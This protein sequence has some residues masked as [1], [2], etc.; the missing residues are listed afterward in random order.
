MQVLKEHNE[1]DK[2][3]I[4]GEHTDSSSLYTSSKMDVI[5]FAKTPHGTQLV[6]VVKHPRFRPVPSHRH[7][8]IE[9][10]FV[11][12]GNVVHMFEDRKV[13]LEAGD[14]LIMN[15]YTSHSVLTAGE[16]DIAVNFIIQSRF[17][18]NAY[19]LTSKHNVLSDFI[20]DLL[21]N[22]VNCNQYLH[23]KAYYHMPIC[24]LIEIVLSNFFHHDDDIST[25]RDNADAELINKTLMSAIF[26]YLSKD[27]SSLSCDSPVNYNEVMLNTVKR[28]IDDQYKTATLSELA[29]IMKQSESALSRQ[30]KNIFGVTFKS[31]LQVKRFQ[32][33]V[34]LLEETKL[35][36]SDIALAVGYENSSYFYRKFREIYTISPKTYRDQRQGKIKRSG[37]K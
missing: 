2:K 32:R 28:Y 31:L 5:D 11:C 12:S 33:A 26:Y 6:S 24:H 22:E 15:Q 10:M 16:N 1:Q 19:A 37:C 30:I 14:L 25:R 34:T 13:T 18:D 29:D 21:R 7:N 35:P 36:V 23:F 20:I 4:C 8:F 3:L 27:L 17:F 9:V